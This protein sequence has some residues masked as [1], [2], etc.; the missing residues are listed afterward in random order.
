MPSV[1]LTELWVHDSDNLADYVTSDGFLSESYRRTAR[2]EVRVY[3][4][5]RERLTTRAGAPQALNVSLPAVDRTTIAWLEDHK[6]ALVMVRDPR[7][8]LVWG[9]YFDLD[10]D[11]KPGGV[12]PDVSFSLRSVTHSVAA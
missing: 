11:E 9:A 2:G 7:G 3:A 1:A 10:V 6:G 5:G 12:L 8:R 4:G